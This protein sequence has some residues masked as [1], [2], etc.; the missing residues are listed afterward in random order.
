MALRLIE[1]VLREKD[2]GE[3]GEQGTQ[4]FDRGRSDDRRTAGA[5]LLKAGQSEA[6]VAAQRA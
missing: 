4:V 2:G 5:D 6:D 1:M 3:V